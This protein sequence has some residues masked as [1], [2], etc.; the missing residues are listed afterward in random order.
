MPLTVTVNE[1]TTSTGAMPVVASATTAGDVQLPK[2]RLGGTGDDEYRGIG[3]TQAVADGGDGRLIHLADRPVGNRTLTDGLEPD[4]DH[5]KA[6]PGNVVRCGAGI[7]S[8][9]RTLTGCDN[10]QRAGECGPRQLVM[11]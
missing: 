4:A 11:V 2:G 1:F 5:L 8:E 3:D 7:A 9:Q 10:A 6:I